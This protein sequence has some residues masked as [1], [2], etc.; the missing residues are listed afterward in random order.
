MYK[1]LP[2]FLQVLAK[3][4][5]IDL[6][7]IFFLVAYSIYLYVFVS[8]TFAPAND[9]ADY[10]SNARSW[11]ENKPLLSVYRPPLISLFISAVWGLTGE[12][13]ITIQYL[14]PLFTI[15]AAIVLYL[16]LRKHKGS[17]FALGVSSLTLLNPAV[18]FWSTQIMTESL[19]LFFIVLSLYF[20]KSEKETHWY[21]AGVCIGLTFASKYSIL[22]EVIIIFVVECIIRKD[23][24]FLIRTTMTAFPIIIATILLVYLKAGT[25]MAAQGGGSGDTHFTYLLSTFYLENSLSIWG[26]SFVLLPLAFVFR[27][28][29]RDKFNYTF[30]AWFIGSLLFWSANPEPLLHDPRYIIQF[31]PAVYYL[32]ILSIENITKLN[33]SRE[34][35]QNIRKVFPLK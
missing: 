22:V 24:K 19:S 25:F 9:A 33:L 28:T 32:V 23:R 29:Y 3:R 20:I 34:S 10:L 11:L 1:R 31:T 16:L 27:R 26:F 5:A 14:E 4:H 7:F 13:W 17:L 30:V 21:L 2:L 12:N 35:F 18:F 8:I 15:C 6:L